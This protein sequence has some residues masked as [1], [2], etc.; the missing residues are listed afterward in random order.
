MKRFN[1]AVLID[2]LMSDVRNILLK[3][4]KL[5]SLDSRL[6]TEQPGAGRW[7]VAQVLEHLNFYS[8]FYIREIEARLH[9]HNT[10]ASET[11][12]AG[13]FGE[14]FTNMMKPKEGGVVKNKMKA[15]KSATPPPSVD[16]QTALELF[17]NDQHQ[18]LNLL[19]VARSA[20]L[21]KIRVPVSITRLITL[22]LGDTFRFF[23]AHEQRHFIQI[24][25]TLEELKGSHRELVPHAS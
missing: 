2:D 15:M 23:I 5:R 22:K 16:G 19:Q 12:R 11:F 13:W 17:I 10:V 9:R 8:K 3:A 1:S 14:Y 4:E 20:N 25:H 18:L 24:Q 7:S 21:E 6:L